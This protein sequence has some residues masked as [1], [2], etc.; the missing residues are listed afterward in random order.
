MSNK[1]S[2]LSRR[3]LLR[4]LGA[5]VA[6]PTFE[7]MRPA[8]SAF[9]APAAGSAPPLR[10]GFVFVPNGAHM[11]AWTPAAEGTDFDLP[12]TLEPLADVRDKLTVLT[13]LTHD[14][15]RANGDGPGDHARSAGVYLTAS[16]PYKTSGANIRA[17]T[18]VD[19]YAAQK[20]G[21]M[22]RFP[23]LEL[24]VEEGRNAGNCDSGYSCAYSS[25]ISWKSPTTPMAKE[26]DPREVFER[27]FGGGSKAEQAENRQQRSKRQQSILDF[28]LQDAKNLRPQL[29]GADVRKLDEYFESIREVERR[30]S[31]FEQQPGHEVE[32]LNID[33]PDGVP[34]EYVDHVRVMYDL[35]AVAYQT[36]STRIA[37]FMMANAGSN[38]SY[39]EIEISDG[40]HSL[41]HHGNK[42][43]KQDKIAQI[44]RFHVEQLAYF[45]NKLA[46]IPEGDGTLLDHTLLMYGS[47]L[48]DGN[49]HNHHDLP[50][51]LLGGGAGTVAS[52]RHVRV[53]RDTPMANLFCSLLDR[54]GAGP[55][56]FADS[57]GRLKEIDA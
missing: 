36:D 56:R 27:L 1:R 7:A 33:R 29:S 54:V 32:K 19:Q 21:H 17:G 44:N 30:I 23:S 26:I 41:S 12:A 42:Q 4:G 31:S 50:I 28:V 18:S 57:T 20:V 47:G 48:G 14:K 9:A 52:G 34:A 13:G 25:N 35:L 40:H 24:G 49:R 15:G 46:S 51:V 39:R 8:P 55:A 3:T 10:L 2:S 37:S 5:A 53:A 11:P 38:R 16:Q 45:I 22:T 6:L 43:E